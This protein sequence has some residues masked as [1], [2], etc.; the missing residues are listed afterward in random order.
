[1]R[2]QLCFFARW[3]RLGFTVTSLLGRRYVRSS[4]LPPAFISGLQFPLLIALLGRGKKLVGSQTG[5]AYAWNTIG[6]LAGSLAGGFG[7]IPKFSAPGVWRMVIV[8]LCAL[9]FVAA[10][11]ASRQ[12]GRWSAMFAPVVIALFAVSMLGA[13][14]PTAFWRHSQIGTGHVTQ[15]QGSANEMRDLMQKFRRE[16]IWEAE[17][18]E[19]SVALS[20]GDG[21]AFIVNGRADG[22]A[23]RDSGTQVMLGLIGAALHPN[24]TSALVIGLGTGSTAGWLA[25][26]PSISK[27]DVVELEPAVMNVAKQ[28]AAVNHD[29][30]MNPKL[31]VT[32]GDA[33]EVLLTTSEKYDLIASEPSNPY[34]AGIAGLFTKEYYRSIDRCLRPDGIFLQWVQAYDIDDATMQVIY[35]TLGSVFSNVETW[36]PSRGDIALMA[37]HS[38]VRFSVDT[39]RNRL[40][41][42]PFKSASLAAWQAAG[43]EDFLGHYVANNALAKTLTQLG[44]GSLNTDD[45]TVIEFSLARSLS[46][47]NG[48]QIA[49]VWESNARGTY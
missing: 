19:S 8:L 28:C 16:T 36:H 14:G 45:R 34:R 39:L 13:T 38:P 2:W 10:F 43:V 35:R 12:R 42:E 20:S 11:L 47:A 26:V 37:S 44:S 5:A 23:K 21:L 33:R 17:G 18:I 3:G 15:F 27:V 49:T 4:F 48:F 6:A 25:A 22:N 40:A 29:A 30:L 24:P 1:M 41:Q 9:S 32:I 7:F 31:H 46:A